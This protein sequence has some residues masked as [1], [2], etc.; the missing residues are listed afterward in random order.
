MGMVAEGTG[1]PL[2][3]PNCRRLWRVAGHGVAGAG[4]VLRRHLPILHDLLDLGSFILKPNF[5]LGGEERGRKRE[6]G[7]KPTPLMPARQAGA[8]RLQDPFPVALPA[9]PRGPIRPFPPRPPDLCVPPGR[10]GPGR[11][12]PGRASPSRAKPSPKRYLCL[13]EPQ[14]GRQLGPLG[15]G[16]VLGLLKPPLQRRQLKAG[17]NSPGFAHFLWFAVHHP[18]LG[19]RHLLL[20]MGARAGERHRRRR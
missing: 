8:P 11:T 9:P 14:R 10:A 6:G 17:I 13:C 16:E 5:H 18:H 15:Q 20:C 7:G 3:F 12:E 4:A 1:R 19:L 2:R